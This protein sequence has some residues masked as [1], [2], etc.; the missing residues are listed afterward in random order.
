M[1]NLVAYTDQFYNVLSKKNCQDV[2]SDVDYQ[3]ISNNSIAYDP[4]YQLQNGEWFHIDLN[5]INQNR[6]VNDKIENPINNLPAQTSLSTIDS[7]DF[8]KIVF[9]LLNDNNWFLFQKIYSSFRF[10]KKRLISF[11]KQ[12]QLQNDPVIILKNIPDALFNSQ[13][14]CLYFQGLDK[15]T[16]IFSNI[17]SLYKEATNQ[18][19]NDFF[20]KDYDIIEMA[21]HYS[22]DKISVVNRKKIALCKSKFSNPDAK[23][24]NDIK[25]YIKDFNLDIIMQSNGRFVIKKNKELSIFLDII[26]E[27]YY[28]T[29]LTNQE[30]I[31]SSTRAI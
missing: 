24:K 25:S 10:Y 29:R 9:F 3:I 4:L 20:K 8:S 2:F 16:S 23:L 1:V 19:I 17:I 26:L 30:R 12:P 15:I 11:S 7:N 5:S 6:Q 22:I 13:N 28:K 31:A 27:K 18:E 21:S 14:G